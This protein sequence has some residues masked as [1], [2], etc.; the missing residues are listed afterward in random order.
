M[1]ITV[2]IM[3]ELCGRTKREEGKYVWTLCFSSARELLRCFHIKLK[4]CRSMM[5]HWV[6]AQFCRATA[7]LNLPL[8]ADYRQP[9]FVQ[10][11]V[12]LLKSFPNCWFQI[13]QSTVRCV[14]IVGHHLEFFVF[15]TG[16]ASLMCESLVAKPNEACVARVLRVSDDHVEVTAAAT[17]AS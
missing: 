3:V 8:N 2:S 11:F 9:R 16:R 5:F 15:L 10:L 4:H 13:W 6:S 17:A 14:G 12:F 1:K 7:G